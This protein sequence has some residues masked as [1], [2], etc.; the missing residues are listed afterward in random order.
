MDS[1]TDIR[2]FIATKKR[3][4]EQSIDGND[5]LSQNKRT[6]SGERCPICNLRI[7][8]GSNQI[9]CTKCKKWLHSRQ[10]TNLRP[11]DLLREELTR[12]FVCACCEIELSIPDPDNMEVNETSSDREVLS[13]ILSELVHLRKEARVWRAIEVRVFELQEDNEKLRRIVQDMTRK[14]DNSSHPAT[15]GRSPPQ[16][17]V[18]KQS[19]SSQSRS[20][21]RSKTPIGVRFSTLKG[22]RLQPSKEKVVR[23][24]DS[25]FPRQ[26]QYTRQQ[27][28]TLEVNKAAGA[29]PKVG[30]PK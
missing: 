26:R 14:S 24:N 25:R 16:R 27:P 15:R 8:A 28:R 9:R 5:D 13:R 19:S 11:A 2:S 30:L 1:Q 17:R 29:S 20:R 10:C 23:N 22:D 4:M 3:P 21:S 7:S 12:N 6:R 18:N